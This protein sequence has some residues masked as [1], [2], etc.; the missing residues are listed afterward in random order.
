M[1]W[2][3]DI[4][5]YICGK[6]QNLKTFLLNKKVHFDR[7]M[8]SVVIDEILEPSLFDISFLSY[9]PSSP[10]YFHITTL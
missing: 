10:L 6:K 5:I 8:T 9:I 7:G 4:R 1:T 3:E 2:I